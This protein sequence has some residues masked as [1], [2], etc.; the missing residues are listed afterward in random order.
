MSS[1]L[2]TDV[3]I[4]SHHYEIIKLRNHKIQQYDETLQLH[5]TV[6]LEMAHRHKCNSVV[7]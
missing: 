1:S 6:R 2:V 5:V 4:L 3:F 7:L